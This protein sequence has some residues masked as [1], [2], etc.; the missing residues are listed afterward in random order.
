MAKGKALGYA[1]FAF[2]GCDYL[3]KGAQPAGADYEYLLTDPSP[4]DGW[5]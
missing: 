2:M 4:G 1:S 3:M 5:F